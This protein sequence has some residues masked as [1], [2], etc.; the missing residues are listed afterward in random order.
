MEGKKPKHEVEIEQED[1]IFGGAGDLDSLEVFGVEKPKVL[2]VGA[3]SNIYMEQD[4]KKTDEEEKENE[5]DK[6]LKEF[7]DFKSQK[8]K[9]KASEQ[10]FHWEHRLDEAELKMT[11]AEWKEYK[12]NVLAKMTPEEKDV[13]EKAIKDKDKQRREEQRRKKK[14][15]KHNKW[16]EKCK[17]AEG[18]K[19]VVE[20]E[21][22]AVAQLDGSLDEEEDSELEED[23]E[24]KNMLEFVAQL[25]GADSGS[26]DSDDSDALVMAVEPEDL[27]T[28]EVVKEEIKTGSRRVTRGA[29]KQSTV[30]SPKNIVTQKKKGK[31]KA[32]EKK[33]G[34]KDVTEEEAMKVDE[35]E[36]VEKNT[37]EVDE[38]MEV[39][40]EKKELSESSSDEDSSGDEAA[41]LLYQQKMQQAQ[42]AKS[43]DSSQESSGGKKEG[44]A[45][46]KEV[47]V[48]KEVPLQIEV[49]LQNQ[50]KIEVPA[51]V[52]KKEVPALKQKQ[53]TTAQKVPK[54][55]KV[56]IA[57]DAADLFGSAS[58]SDSEEEKLELSPQKRVR[59]LSS[60]EDEEEA[61]LRKKLAG[62]GREAADP[63]AVKKKLVVN[64]R[65][66]AM[67]KRK[68]E[69]K[70][71]EDK[72][73]EI[74]ASKRVEKSEEDEE[75]EDEGGRF[76]RF[77]SSSS[78]KTE[79]AGVRG[80]ARG[81]LLD[82]LLDGQDSMLKQEK[83]Q[84]EKGQDHPSYQV[85]FI[86]AVTL[87][88]TS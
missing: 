41:L 57:P 1:D 70:D 45:Q 73:R 59:P 8:E 2:D 24:E 7:E 79:N 38:Q 10:F 33:K 44:P 55:D 22:V 34:L 53:E 86:K 6:E 87:A 77:A 31:G 88:T 29:S 67:E 72:E 83:Q 66:K 82:S 52:K 37:M 65:L 17:M 39:D 21:A 16:L 40:K 43:L 23:E 19:K 54:V 15:I 9:K 68:E 20:G 48:Q 50:E 27:D 80:G 74:R 64:K 51:E 75:S 32:A 58:E 4:E 61:N 12:E 25:D 14:E 36:V 81:N 28:E 49:P 13:R 35:D 62:L 47:P 84:D 5:F 18:E 71:K 76:D 85:S 78:K 56:D 11:K 60:S 69:M 63:K 3:V 26:E 30:A 42:Q 46:K